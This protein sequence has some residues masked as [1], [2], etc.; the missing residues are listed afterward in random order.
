MCS[1]DSNFICETFILAVDPKAMCILID[2]GG[3]ARMMKH[4]AA[5][6]TVREVDA[7]SY[8]HMPL[9]EALKKPMYRDSIM[10]LLGSPQIR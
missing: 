1:A 7:D 4:L 10:F 2:H 3:T 5:M 6:G 8:T 9:S